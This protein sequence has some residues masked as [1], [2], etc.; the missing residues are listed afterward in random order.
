M[1]GALDPTNRAV[2]HNDQLSRNSLRAAIRREGRKDSTAHVT[3]TRRH[4]LGW[5]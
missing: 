2:R 4:S 3:V 5:L 1:F